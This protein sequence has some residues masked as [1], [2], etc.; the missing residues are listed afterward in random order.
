MPYYTVPETPVASAARTANGQSDPSDV[1]EHLEAQIL[2][3]ITAVAGTSPT[4]DAVIE[5]SADK[6]I[7]FT[8]TA[9]AQKTAA[10]KDAL[11]LTNLGKFLRV[12]WTLGG[13]SPS[14]TFS[15]ALVGKGLR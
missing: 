11:K 12:R 4:L 2:L 13:T 1:S 14:F 6:A 7:W 5:T 10:G 9:F 3:D 8:H 15:V